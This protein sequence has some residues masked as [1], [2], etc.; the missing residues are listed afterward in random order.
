MT[1]IYKLLEA[2]LN[3]KIKK[4]FLAKY[5]K[6]NKKKKKKKSKNTP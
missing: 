2:E 1:Q 6:F 3:M 4:M 5:H